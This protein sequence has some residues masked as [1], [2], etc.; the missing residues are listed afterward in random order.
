MDGLHTHI[1]QTTQEV[2][3]VKQLIEKNFLPNDVNTQKVMEEIELILKNLQE[4]DK[5]ATSN[6]QEIGD[7]K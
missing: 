5:N 2:I 3:R 4:L 6:R 7:K 1:K